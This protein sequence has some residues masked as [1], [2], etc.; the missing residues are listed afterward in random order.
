[1]KIAIVGVG[2]VGLVT[3][4]CLADVGYTVTCVDNNPDKV[5]ALKNGENPIFEPGLDE[6]LQRNINNE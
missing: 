6:L 2:Y 5:V 3:G 1:M 4:T